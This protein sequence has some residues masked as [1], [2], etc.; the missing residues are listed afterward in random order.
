M[1]GALMKALE[2][3]PANSGPM[4]NAGAHAKKT[5]V[6]RGA[7]IL[8]FGSC[9]SKGNPIGY[10][11]PHYADMRDAIIKAVGLDIEIIEYTH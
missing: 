8:A 7:T 1:F 9:V 5:M 4:R 2:S 6:E 3:R 10:P 11:C